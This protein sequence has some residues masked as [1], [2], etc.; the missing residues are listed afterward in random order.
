MISF[1]LKSWNAPHLFPG[2]LKLAVSSYTMILEVICAPLVSSTSPC[3]GLR[4]FSNLV[5]CYGKIHPACSAHLPPPPIFLKSNITSACAYRKNTVLNI[6]TV[7]RKHNSPQ[8]SSSG[9]CKMVFHN[10]ASC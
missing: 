10:I 1:D 3:L 2:C 9:F 6:R 5:Q 4:S 7:G 8:L